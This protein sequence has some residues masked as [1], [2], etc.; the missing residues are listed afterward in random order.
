[1]KKI[2]PIAWMRSAA[3]ALLVLV[4][5]QL[6]HSEKGRLALMVVRWVR[7]VSPLPPSSEEGRIGSKV[8][9]SVEPV[10]R[11]LTDPTQ[12]LWSPAITGHFWPKM[13]FRHLNCRKSA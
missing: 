13:A 4:S 9:F 10:E 11:P 3:S 12:T 1:M 8:S 5:M 2:N 7:S 6:A